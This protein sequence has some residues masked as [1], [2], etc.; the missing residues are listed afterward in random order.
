M[1]DLLSFE[2]V[3]PARWSP[4]RWRDVAALAPLMLAMLAAAAIDWRSRRI[5]NWLTFTLCGLGLLNGVAASAGWLVG[6]GVVNG[7]LGFL[8]G[9]ALAVPLFILGARG[10]GDA[11]L[12]MA[13]GVWI[14]PGGILALFLVEAIVGAVFVVGRAVV[15]GQLAHLAS[16]TIILATT[17]LNVRRL[18]LA[19]TAAAGQHLTVYNA[20]G[21]GG[22]GGGGGEDQEGSGFKSIDRPL[23]HAV[24]ALVA[25]MLCLLLGHV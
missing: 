20:G 5:P 8:V 3:S 18:G 1:P 13:A 25:L 7:L 11:K 4:D 16:N 14:G 6:V 19:T 15:R 22:G 10:A 12:Y 24:P 9:A 17:L 2:I 23:P 21:G